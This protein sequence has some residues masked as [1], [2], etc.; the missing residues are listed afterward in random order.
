MNQPETI[1]DVIARFEAAYQP[2]VAHNDEKRHFHGVYYR[3]TI[4]VKA[5]MERAGFLDPGWVEPWD[6]VLAN[7]YLDALDQWNRGEPPSGPWQVAFQAAKDP[8]I[9]PLRHVLAGLDVHLNYDLPQAFLAVAT[10][11]EINQPALLSKRQQDFQHIY[12][13][14]VSRIKEENLELKKAE[15]PGDRTVMDRMLT[16]FNRRA[17]Q[18]FLNEAQAQVWRN[19]RILGRARRRSPEAYARCLRQLEVLTVAKAE[20]LLALSRV[21]LRL[22]RTGFG[23]R[24]AV[25]YD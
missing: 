4:A 12:S 23:V 6:V 8:S 24:L 14:E 25:E 20:E 11:D 15:E 5:D 1:S 21:Q 16:P 10:D 9:P 18:R 7:I 22:A 2:L 13:I 3:N 17:S 19:T